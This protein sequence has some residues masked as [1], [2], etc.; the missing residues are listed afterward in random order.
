M[1]AAAY[2]RRTCDLA[3]LR[4]IAPA[5]Q[6]ALDWLERYGDV[7]G[8]GLVEYARRT[9]HGLVQ[10]GWKDSHDSVFHQDGR[11]AE[12]PIALVEVHVCFGAW[13]AAAGSPK[14]W[15]SATAAPARSAT[16]RRVD[17]RPLRRR[18][19]TRSWA[20]VLALDGE[21]VPAASPARTSGTPCGPASS[22]T[23]RARGA[24]P[25]A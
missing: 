5:V 17:P 8:D 9:P 19:G 24:S 25:T 3:F 12:A 22:R 13:Q 2:Y 10:Q 11:L 1:L 6:R 15:T 16:A 23:R 21:K 18:S 4:S 7:D 14:H 20:Y